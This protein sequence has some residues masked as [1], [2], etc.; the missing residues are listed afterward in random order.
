MKDQNILHIRK[1]NKMKLYITRHGQTDG[2]VNKIMDGIRDIDLNNNGIEQAKLTRDELKDIKFDLIIS[3]PLTRT[4]H[5]M[6]IININNYQVLYDDRIKERDCGEF[7]GLTFD[8]L[9]RD[10]YW[11]YNDKTIYEKAESL[12]ELFKRVYNFLDEIKEKYKDKTILLVTHEG[13]T[14]VINCY[15]NGIPEDGNLQNLGLKNCE[16]K[17]YDL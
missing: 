11:N 9:D 3:S 2:N 7:T 1:E 8:S 6:E 15:F 17:I 12:K 14:K 5:T 13:I 10:L 4:K 16:V